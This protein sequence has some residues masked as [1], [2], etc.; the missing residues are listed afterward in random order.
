MGILV[1][2]K[3]T[4]ETGRAPPT[5]DHVFPL[6]VKQARCNKSVSTSIISI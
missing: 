6:T 4:D 1:K 3:H 5:Y 2:E